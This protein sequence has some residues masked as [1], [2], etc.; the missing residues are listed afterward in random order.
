MAKAPKWKPGTGDVL[1]KKTFGIE[2]DSMITETEVKKMFPPVSAKNIDK[3]LPFILDAI[4]EF[5]IADRDMTLV[6]LA[7]I[8]AETEGFLPI[9]EGQSK[10]NTSANGHPFDLYDGRFG[11]DSPGD[12]E[13]Y[14]GRGFVQLTFKA[15]YREI[16]GQIGVPLEAVPEL[17]N[18]PKQAARV[19]ARF[20]KNKEAKIRAAVAGGDMAMARKQVNGGSHG[21]DRFTDAFEKGAELA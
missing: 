3:Y 2:D 18:D 19:L 15:N 11:N 10:Y 7:T 14:K 21:L 17:A 13:R 4:K 12:G 9:S 8:R 6:A 20:L 1:L 16:G 5:N